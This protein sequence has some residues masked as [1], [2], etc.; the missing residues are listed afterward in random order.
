MKTAAYRVREI[1]SGHSST[2]AIIAVDTEGHEVRLE[3]GALEG[4][5]IHVDEVLVLSWA[6]VVV[7]QP[8]T[9]ITRTTTTTTPSTSHFE[10]EPLLGRSLEVEESP[11]EELDGRLRGQAG[12]R[13]HLRARPGRDQPLRSSTV[14][15]IDEE[16]SPASSAVRTIDEELREIQALVGLQ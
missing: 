14:G 16:E 5:S 4:A 8:A 11:G 3:V 7:P 10:D 6:T 15:T 9:T 1:L 12:D 2:A 13:Q